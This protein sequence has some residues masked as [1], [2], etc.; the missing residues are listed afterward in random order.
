MEGTITLVDLT[1]RYRDT[2]AVDRLNFE[3]TPGRVTGFLGPNGAGKSTTMRMILGLTLPTSGT[4][5][6]GNRPYS[7]LRDPL[8]EVGALLDAGAVHP[9]RT[10]AAHLRALARSNRIQPSRVARVLD[11]VGLGAAADRKVGEFSLGMRQRLGVA[12]AILGDPGV[13]LF[14][15]PVNG[16]DPEGVV[17]IRRLMRSMA[18]EGRTVLVSS[19]LMSEMEDT[20]DQ[21]IVMGRGRLLADAPMRELVGR[22]APT[23]RIRTP[24]VDALR[25]AVLEA[26]LTVEQTDAEELAV[27]DV[28]PSDLGEIAFRIGARVHELTHAR[29]TLEDAYLQLTAESVEYS[30]ALPATSGAGRPADDH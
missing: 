6:I 19:H 23:V 2:L 18:S 30:S 10:A 25:R 7:S 14:D 21:V 1:K 15:E 12:T 26:G 9:G 22:T 3:I 5:L 11:T 24:Q 17:W 8:R 4:S 28:H 20:A 16:L 27:A 13:L 29:S